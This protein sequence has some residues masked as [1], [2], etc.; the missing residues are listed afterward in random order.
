[1]GQ[2]RFQ[3]EHDVDDEP[4]R[5]ER[6]TDPARPTAPACERAERVREDGRADDREHEAARL[7][8]ATQRQR[9][10]DAQRGER[11]R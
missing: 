5:L 1:V 7:H 3:D 8:D 4:D 6:E 2:P 9:S 11:E 10:G